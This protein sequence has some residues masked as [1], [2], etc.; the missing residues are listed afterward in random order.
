MA[1]LQLLNPEVLEEFLRSSDDLRRFCSQAEL[2]DME[3]LSHTVRTQ[4]EA[5]LHA[6]AGQRLVALKMLC[7]TVSPE[8]TRLAARAQLKECER[9]LETVQMVTGH[10]SL[11]AASFHGQPSTAPL[12][13]T[14]S[15]EGP[16]GPKYAQAIV[17]ADNVGIKQMAERTVIETIPL[18]DETTTQ[19]DLERYRASC[20]AFKSQLDRNQQGLQSE[21]PSGPA[22]PSA[23]R[24]HLQQLQ[25]LKQDTEGLWFEFELQYSQCSQLKGVEHSL[26]KE[27]N[28]LLQQWRAQQIHLQRRVKSLGAAMG[29]LSPVDNQM[30]LIAERLDHLF[31]K[32]K[33]IHGFT[34]TNPSAAEED[35]KDLEEK[36]QREMD[37][38]TGLDREDSQALRELDPEARLALGHALVGSRQ[39]LDQLRQRV[40]R[41]G[42]AVR[43]LDRFL[44]SLRGVERDISST[45]VGVPV[46]ISAPRDGRSR[47]APIRQSV[48]AAG[49]EA[50]RVDRLLEEARFSLTQ[51]G[52]PA[53]C[54]DLVVVLSQRLEEADG[55]F[56]QQWQEGS[57]AN[58]AP[59]GQR[60]R[61]MMRV[62]REIRS[63]VESQGLKE[64]TLPAVQRRMRSLADMEARLAAQRT[65]M[66]SLREATAQMDPKSS[67][68]NPMEELETLWEEVNGT[69]TERKEQCRALTEL[70]KRFQ[71]CRSN[72][73]T[74]L[75]RAEQTVSERAS[76]M[77]KDNL[78]RLITKV[79]GIKDEVAGLAQGEADDLVDRWLDVTEKT[80]SHMDSL[81]VGVE[82]WA[83]LMQLGGEV[84]S[85]TDRKLAAFTEGH[86]FHSEQDIKALQDEIQD[87]EESLE[88]FHK[89]S[90]EIQEL[91]QSKEP[92]LD[93]QVMETQ[94]RKKME[95][96]RELF[97]E[98]SDVFQC[99]V[100]ARERI[101]QRMAECQSA[102][103]DIQTSLSMLDTSQTPSALSHIQALS[104]Q[105]QLQAE[106]TDSILEE[107]KLL[108]GVA[109]PQALEKLA[110]Q[111][112]Q[113]KEGIHSTQD[114]I[115]Q[116]RLEVQKD[117]LKVTKSHTKASQ[118]V[119][120]VAP[121]GEE[122]DSEV[123]QDRASAHG[124]NEGHPDQT[125]ASQH[126]RVQKSKDMH[127]GVGK[128]PT[129][130]KPSEGRKQTER[131]VTGGPHHDPQGSAGTAGTNVKPSWAQVAGVDAGRGKGAQ[132]G[133]TKLLIT[134]R[135]SSETQSAALQ[136]RD[137]ATPVMD[138]IISA[139]QGNT[140]PQRG[141]DTASTDRVRSEHQAPVLPLRS[142]GSEGPDSLNTVTI[143]TDM[144]DTEI[145]APQTEAQTTETPKARETDPQQAES[146]HR[147]HPEK[148]TSVIQDTDTKSSQAL[149]GKETTSQCTGSLVTD[150]QLDSKT[151]TQRT[152][153]RVCEKKVVSIGLDTDVT[154]ADAQYSELLP[155]ESTESV[156]MDPPTGKETIK[157]FPSDN[158]GAELRGSSGTSGAGLKGSYDSSGGR[159][160]ASSGTSGAGLKESSGVQLRGSRDVSVT[161]F[162]NTSET[163]GVT[164]G[165]CKRPE[166]ALTETAVQKPPLTETDPERTEADLHSTTEALQSQ[167]R[168]V[169]LILDTDALHVQTPEARGSTHADVLRILSSG[170]QNVPAAPDMP[171]AEHTDVLCTKVPERQCSANPPGQVGASPGETS[172][173][174]PTLARPELEGQTH[175][176]QSQHGQTPVN[177]AAES[178]E[179]KKAEDAGISGHPDSVISVK[180]P[181]EREGPAKAP[182][183]GEDARPARSDRS[184]LSTRPALPVLSTTLGQYL[185]AT[186][187]RPREP[188]PGWTNSR[189]S[190]RTVL[191]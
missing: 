153:G 151:S 70:L 129:N 26:E 187:W 1:S 191:K 180:A 167:Q 146:G 22:T 117:P 150:K 112:R 170:G 100:V 98:S 119:A 190:F 132:T 7:D 10:T 20:S 165:P 103:R 72:L 61:A 124:R 9:R 140:L 121:V 58:S 73:C 126:T 84:E 34:L 106:Q 149:C 182:V 176:S 17:K 104:A 31:E 108:L 179:K 65:E 23:L 77:G 134:D 25:V 54:Q 12:C 155:C 90:S 177:R 157:P 175:S 144:Q 21:F 5:C 93:L 8:E 181:G 131:T 43:A 166:S 44:L 57:R 158:S 81:Q 163:S 48:R 142:T 64:P 85:W 4:W 101:S 37:R 116:K 78:Q 186:S 123:M 120:Q 171:Q 111:G 141:S 125:G 168:T 27:R 138:K 28:E 147:Q 160:K 39:T 74:T 67:Q 118:Q 152:S 173:M 184:R 133:H 189:R 161:G 137:T 2:R 51:D 52:S 62:L 97:S 188:Q 102:L 127:A 136:E 36:I 46:D 143:E 95:Q 110:V 169:A 6:E 80:E 183:T 53:S 115:G 75:Q 41:G 96:V 56:A 89:R 76:Y 113:L 128:T 130:E 172:S 91:L 122:V 164:V 42:A 83:K 109:S 40:W 14:D 45:R 145:Q 69:V 60:T 49:D 162:S 3:V 68:G 50:A 71:S 135:S 15:S 59:L 154:M 35:I 105:L 86:P 94:L 63:S 114:L 99:V 174:D 88:R 33:D 185:T 19:E 38:L 30:T 139:V 29:L 18:E 55:R 82:L 66:Q 156:S 13:H 79:H 159:L 11:T 107:V 178:D 87:Q 16:L 24:I 148:V 92:P 32:P 47:L